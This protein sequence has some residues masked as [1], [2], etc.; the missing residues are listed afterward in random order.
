MKSVPLAAVPSRE[1]IVNQSAKGGH[2]DGMLI[3][4]VS[5]GN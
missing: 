1:E 2:A 3:S 5:S 4:A